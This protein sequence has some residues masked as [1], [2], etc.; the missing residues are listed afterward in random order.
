MTTRWTGYYTKSISPT[1]YNSVLSLQKK[2]THDTKYEL[3]FHGDR[4]KKEIALTFDADMTPYMRDMLTSG[5]VQSYY[6]E[7]V[8]D[9]LN[10]TKTKATLFLTG[11][12]IELYPDVAK[13]LAANSLFELGNHSYSHP[14]FDG[15]CFGL[16]EIPDSEDEHQIEATQQLLQSVA[17]VKAVVFRFPGGCAS[18]NDIKQVV[19]DGLVPIQWDDAGDDGFNN[20]IQSII[21]NVLNQAQN[22]SIIVL[23]MNGY[24]NDPQTG[25]ALPTIIATLKQRGFSFVTVSELLDDHKPIQDLVLGNFLHTNE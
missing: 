6:N 1:I 25:V 9:V 17:G 2:V 18:K 10:Q 4:S 8:I 15:T 13:Q 23:H 5:Q 22:G 12:W 20:N 21:N 24:P 3:V 19:D 16:G 14:S 11:M 7:Q